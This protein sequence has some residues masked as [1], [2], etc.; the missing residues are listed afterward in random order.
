[1]KMALVVITMAVLSFI[2][3]FNMV[4]EDFAKYKLE[5]ACIK[6][7]IAD[8]VARKDVEGCNEYK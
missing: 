4:K 3:L 7:Q 5:G 2:N 1:M 8:G 6:M